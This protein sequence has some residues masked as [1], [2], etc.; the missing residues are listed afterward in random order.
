MKTPTKLAT[1]GLVAIFGL[2]TGSA[3]AGDQ[4]SV[5][6]NACHGW[7][8][9]DEDDLSYYAPY[10]ASTSYY[11]VVTCPMVRDDLA[12]TDLNNVALHRF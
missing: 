12:S 2:L 11:T 10:L 9:E 5:S 7:K 3:H 6:G 1:L 4:K 8:A